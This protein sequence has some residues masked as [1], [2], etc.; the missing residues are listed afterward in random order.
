MNPNVNENRR[1]EISFF[2]VFRFL[3]FCFDKFWNDVDIFHAKDNQNEKSIK[4]VILRK[5]KKRK[6]FIDCDAL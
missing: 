3:F 2:I 5:R 4:S 1:I 6:I